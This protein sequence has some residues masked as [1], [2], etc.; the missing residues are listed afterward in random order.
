MNSTIIYVVVASF[1][2]YQVDN[3]SMKKYEM[4]DDDDNIVKVQFSK[5]NDYSCPI[6][7]DLNHYHYAKDISRDNNAKDDEWSIKYDKNDNGTIKYD[8]NG[9]EINSYKVIKNVRRPKS[10]PKVNVVD[11]NE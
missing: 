6:S 7:C 10:A 5:K 9:N 3:F 4:V 11:I 8:I 2:A 1:I